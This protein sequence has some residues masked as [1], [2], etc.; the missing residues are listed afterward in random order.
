MTMLLKCSIRWYNETKQKHV[1]TWLIKQGK[2]MKIRFD[3]YKISLLTQLFGISA[4]AVRLYEKKGLLRPEKKINNYRVFSRNDFFDVEYISR[5]KKM[6]FSLVDIYYLLTKASTSDLKFN[7]NKRLYEIRE[8]EIALEVAR[9]ETED[10]LSIISELEDKTEKIE[11]VRDVEIICC[12]IT[13]TVDAAYEV[14]TGFGIDD[15]PRLTAVIHNILTDKI[16]NDMTKQ[17]MELVY[18]VINCGESITKGRNCIDDMPEIMII[19]RSDYIRSVTK[20]ATRNSSQNM[21]VLS[22][23]LD[24]NGIEI[25]GAAY[26]RCIM[27]QKI[28]DES[29][30]YYETWIQIKP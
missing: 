11:I 18:S 6:G 26:S 4:D 28:H 19:P 16:E 8:R 20:T 14:L 1:I 29:E 10:V 3:E 17:E 27:G 9:R 22:R 21:G 15:N 25:T 2:K 24:E 13:G 12:D 30:N 7:L 23:F 5:L